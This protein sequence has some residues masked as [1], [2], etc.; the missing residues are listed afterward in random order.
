M[1]PVIAAIG[2][3]AWLWFAGKPRTQ[4]GPSALASMTTK[5]GTP[6]GTQN[7]PATSGRI[8]RVTHWVSGPEAIVLALG[9]SWANQTSA[10]NSLY[11]FSA[12]ASE[13]PTFTKLQASLPD[14]TAST[15][16][17]QLRTSLGA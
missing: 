9:G 17:I 15:D 8:Y 6:I 2:V 5:Y 11:A 14:A 10:P 13:P 3:G 12:T 7:W 16:M 4:S 1:L